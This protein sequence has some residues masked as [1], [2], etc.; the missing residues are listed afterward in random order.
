M[1][2]THHTLLLLLTLAMLSGLS[3]PVSAHAESVQ[4]E[5]ILVQ[6]ANGEGGVDAALRPYAGTLQRLFRFKSYTQ[7]GR[8]VLRLAVP[9]E[10]S[11]GL[12]NGQRLQMKALS[13][14]AEQG[15]TAEMEWTRGGSRLVHT[16][17]Q[18]RPGNPA[19]MGGPS[20]QEGTWLLILRLR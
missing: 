19:V 17:L 15:L 10:G 1:K 6:A 12:A 3:A 14:S 8:Q 9:G 18:L 5:V 16:R 13:G 11:V 7:A 4:V 2:S 20:G